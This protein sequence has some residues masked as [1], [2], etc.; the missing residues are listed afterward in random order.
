[1]LLEAAGTAVPA[2]VVAPGRPEAVE[3]GARALSASDA[4]RRRLER[5]LHDGAQQRLVSLAIQLRLLAM[6]LTPDSHQSRLLAAAQ[7]Q[8]AAS[9]QELRELAAGL[10]PAV[11][12]R[13]LKDALIAVATRAPLPV[14][15][16]V[17][18]EPR[19]SAPVEVAA[20]YLVS[21]TLTNVAKHAGATSATVTVAR[22]GDRLI[23]DVADDGAGGADPARGSGL[24]GLAD[25]I[26]A[27]GGSVRVLSPAGLGT[28]V[29][30]E[31]PIAPG[32][33]PA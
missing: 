1:M 15:V 7:E 4:E 31:I 12:E 27:L 3:A 25:R 9:L 21:E 17:D 23:V 14:S 10:H 2:S 16:A 32:L 33:A 29:H 13:G 28:T 24:R 18:V 19:P 26:D 20:Y 5:D 11:L 22:A 30:A 6:D 8:L